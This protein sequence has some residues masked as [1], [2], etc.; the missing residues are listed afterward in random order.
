VSSFLKLE[1]FS[2]LNVMLDAG[3]W[4]LAE[5]RIFIV[6]IKHPASSNQHRSASSKVIFYQLTRWID[7][8]ASL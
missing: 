8:L 3:L 7:A 2:R 6:F 5:I 1:N 4:M